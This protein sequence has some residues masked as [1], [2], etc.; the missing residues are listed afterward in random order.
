MKKGTAD[1]SLVRH[2]PGI[3]DV[4]RQGKIFNTVPKKAYATST[5]TDKKT[6]EFT[7]ELAT[8]MFTNYGSMCIVLLIQI[9]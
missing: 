6:I 3:S 2:I 5:Y 7:L 1:A 4:W 9:K 8:N